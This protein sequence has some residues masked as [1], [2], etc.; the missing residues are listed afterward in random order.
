[1]RL[2]CPFTCL[3]LLGLSLTGFAQSTQ[4]TPAS[5]GKRSDAWTGTVTYT[6]TQSM[7]ENK[8]TDRVSG[9]GKDTRN[10]EMKYDYKAVVGVTDDPDRQGANLGKAS[11]THS[12][13]SVET[14]VAV[15]KNSC[16]RGKTWREMT[17]TFTSET[18]VSGEGKEEANVHGGMNSGGRSP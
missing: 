6:R 3:F 4:K 2:F 14:T 9:R 11:I 5:G 1:M 18:A 12:F 17:G 16:D 13:S 10:W 8:T 7:T 15:E